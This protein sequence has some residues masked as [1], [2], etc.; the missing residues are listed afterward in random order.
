MRIVT[1]ASNWECLEHLVCNRMIGWKMFEHGVQS[2]LDFFFPT[3][4]FVWFVCLL[5]TL[6]NV[7]L[8]QIEWRKNDKTVARG[9]RKRKCAGKRIYYACAMNWTEPIRYADGIHGFCVTNIF[10]IVL[11]VMPSTLMTFYFM[12]DHQN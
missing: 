1:T 7:F 5:S 3:F 8:H 10:K 6:S 12:C 4:F 11:P 2:I 9:R